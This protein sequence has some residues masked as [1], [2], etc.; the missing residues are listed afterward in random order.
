MSESVDIKTFVVLDLETNAFPS[1]NFNTCSVTEFSIY[2]F[3]AECLINKDVYFKRFLQELSAEGVDDFHQGPPDLP[4][5]LHK[6][7]LMIRP[8]GLIQQS[9]EDITGLNNEM[10]ENQSPFDEG[11]ATCIN[12]FLGRLHEPV[13]IVAHN[14]W[15][16]DFPIVRYVY[17]K[18]NKLLPSS[19]L[20]VDSLKAFREIDE[21]YNILK[22]ALKVMNLLVPDDELKK[23]ELGRNNSPLTTDPFEENSKIDWQGINETSPQKKKPEKPT[24]SSLL[25]ELKSLSDSDP[26]SKKLRVK[27]SLFANDYTLSKYP[28]KSLYKLG[29]IYKRCF[30]QHAVNLHRAEK[31][32]EVLTKLMFHYGT[33]FLAYADA[34][35]QLFS[36]VPKLGSSTN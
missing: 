6:L 15:S 19:I 8:S 5:V 34:R 1:E 9:A 14:G 18:C 26:P 23:N 21:K 30:S 28:K 17:E 10:L 27:R 12:Q 29:T 2:A 3:S 13:C 24:Y 31:D 4:R 25:N 32:V 7:T 20:C 16:Y 11:T 22:N 33:D 35:K 36:Q